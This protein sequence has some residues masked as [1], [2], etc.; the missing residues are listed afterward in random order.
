MN[1]FALDREGNHYTNNL[2]I[3]RVQY[4]YVAVVDGNEIISFVTKDNRMG[5][6]RST[7]SYAVTPYQG[8]YFVTGN[9]LEEWCARTSSTQWVKNYQWENNDGSKLE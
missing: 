1:L 4:A 5:T 7:P 3:D 6:L 9:Q 8:K 2:P